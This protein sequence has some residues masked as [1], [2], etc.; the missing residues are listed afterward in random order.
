MMTIIGARLQRFATAGALGV[1]TDTRYVHCFWPH[2]DRPVALFAAGSSGIEVMGPPTPR[3]VVFPADT[4]FLEYLPD[5]MAVAQTAVT[6][7][8]PEKRGLINLTEE[9]IAVWQNAYDA[10]VAVLPRT[11]ARVTTA[12]R[13]LLRDPDGARAE[14]TEV[15][16]TDLIAGRVA[17]AALRATKQFRDEAGNVVVRAR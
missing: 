7:A 14:I 15:E 3:N 11:A 9:Q 6:S 12:K 2:L 16:A 8:F 5:A 4:V 17:E 13:F 1:V 10:H